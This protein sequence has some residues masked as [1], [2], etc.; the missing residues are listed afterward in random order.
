MPG[1]ERL[2]AKA[3]L[4]GE[5]AQL[6]DFS[7]VAGDVID[8]ASL[9]RVHDGSGVIPELALRDDLHSPIVAPR[10]PLRYIAFG[11][12]PRTSSTPRHTATIQGF[13]VRH[14]RYDFRIV[15]VI[16]DE[17][18]ELARARHRVESASTKVSNRS[19]CAL[20]LI[21]QGRT[22]CPI[23]RSFV[24]LSTSERSTWPAD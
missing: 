13:E 12:A 4:A 22:S 14:W 21:R 6:G 20:T 16:G 10:V 15:W 9:D 19:H 2:G 1:Y 3:A 5:R 8:L 17:G 24:S 11:P 23:A 18:V 7:A